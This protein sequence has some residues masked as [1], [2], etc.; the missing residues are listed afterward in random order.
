MKFK[1]IATMVAVIAV[2][3]FSSV[4]A[5]DCGSGGGYGGYGAY[6]GVVESGCGGY[7][8]YGDVGYSAA[9]CYRGISSSCLLYTSP[10][11]RDRQKSRMPS[12]A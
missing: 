3:G 11:P 2:A 12:S 1:L 6:S 7:G 9:T 5:Q 4:Q 8:S 10:S